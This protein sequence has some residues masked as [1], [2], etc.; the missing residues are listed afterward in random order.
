MGNY[1]CNP[2]AAEIS[3]QC[4]IEIDQ[5]SISRQG[6]A[7]QER[8]R[9]QKN[10]ELI[11]KVQAALRRYHALRKVQRIK[12]SRHANN[13][14]RESFGNLF[15]GTFDNHQPYINEIVEQRLLELGDFQYR[16]DSRDIAE[17][18][19]IVFVTELEHKKSGKYTGQIDKVTNKRE[20]RGIQV[21]PDG[22]R[23]DGSW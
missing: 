16:E 12:L 11:I 15:Q 5:S 3:N 21:W 17:K 8:N 19:N 4:T 18:Q 1:C 23:Y 14:L 20:G 6:H 7:N 13:Q 9:L 22:S 2:K 10:I